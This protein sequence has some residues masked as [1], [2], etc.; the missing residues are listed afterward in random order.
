MIVSSL[1]SLMVR[2]LGLRPWNTVVQAMCQFTNQ[3]SQKTLDE[4]WLVEHPPVFTQGQ[5]GKIKNIFILNQIPVMQSDRGGQLTYHGPGQQIMY[6]MIDL[7]RRSITTRQLIDC[8][9]KTIID[10]LTFFSVVSH[11]QSRAPGVYV[12]DKKIGSLGLRIRKGCSYHGLSLNVNMDLT[13]FLHIN[14]CGYVG[15]KMTQ[16]Q[17]H[18]NSVTLTDVQPILIYNFARQLSISQIHWIEENEI[19]SYEKTS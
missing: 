7:K 15:L 13:P 10:T 1:D 2:K 4:V 12:D 11:T 5:S 17:E 8:I 3:R 16:L 6:V 9:E 14:P 18:K 19:C